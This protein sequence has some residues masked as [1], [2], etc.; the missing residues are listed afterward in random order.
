MLLQ[1]RVAIDGTVSAYFANA[2]GGWTSAPIY[3]V[4]TTTLIFDAGDEMIPFYQ[5]VNIGNGNPA[6]SI[7]E[8]FAIGST[9][10]V[11]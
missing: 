9:S 10:A 2:T 8:F 7:G 4:G 3:S 1:I 11:A 6:I 5:H